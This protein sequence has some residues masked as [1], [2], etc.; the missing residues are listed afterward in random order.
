MSNERPSVKQDDPKSANR[1][2]PI[3]AVALPAPGGTLKQYVAY[4][5]ASGRSCA[6]SSD[7]TQAWV[8][9][10][11]GELRR[12]PMECTQPPDA[13]LVKS[14]LGRRGVWMVTYLLA[15]D[16]SHPA[17]CFDYV[18]RN[19]DYRLEALSSH[20]RRDI[21]RGLR[22][23]NVRLCTWDELAAKGYP[24]EVDTTVQHGY[25]TP[26]SRVIRKFAQRRRRFPLFEIWGAWKGE[27]LAAWMSVIKVDDWAA[28]DVCR[29]RTARLR[30]CPNNALLYAATRTLLV[31]E[32][33]KYVSYGLSSL[34]VEVNDLAMHQYKVRMG[35]EAVPVW[36]TV[37]LHWTLGPLLKPRAASLGWEAMAKLLP[38]LP[39]LRRAAGLARL[40]SGRDSAP[41]AW[42]QAE[43]A[44]DKD[45]PDS[46]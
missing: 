3:A 7:G 15:P 38:K 18:C 34:Q 37:A 32:K 17:N 27:E 5:E 24:A 14:L 30:H 19:P 9:G 4:E 16:E 11:R 22:S 20:A 6:L 46:T 2:P 44:S 29:S 10:V 43:G 40:L 36:R 26:S 8:A 1:E 12:L 35:Y 25:I 33:R 13:D 21:R 31:E 39:A 41:L 28:I 42:A 23:F 45:S